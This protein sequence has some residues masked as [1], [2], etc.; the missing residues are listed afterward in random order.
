M[1]YIYIFALSQFKK[2][3]AVAK[4]TRH[5]LWQRDFISDGVA[6]KNTTEKLQL[7]LQVR[8][9]HLQALWLAMQ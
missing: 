4:F 1:K 9:P 6:E 3:S 7:D 8:S 2:L 5:V